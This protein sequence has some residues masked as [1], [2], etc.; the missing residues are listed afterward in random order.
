MYRGEEVPDDVAS[1]GCEYRLGVELDPRDGVLA[2]VHAYY[3][4]GFVGWGALTTNAPGTSTV[5][6][7]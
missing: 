6:S 4:V 2:M 7:E 3:E 1:D 5:T